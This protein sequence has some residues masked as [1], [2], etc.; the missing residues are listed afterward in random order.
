MKKIYLFSLFLFTC[1]FSNITYSQTKNRITVSSG[2]A[3]N[4]LFKNVR[5][6]GGG[7]S[8]GKG[9]TV[10]GLRYSRMLSNSFSIESGLEYSINR[11]QTTPAF[12]P[13]I[14]QTPKKSSI[15]MLSLPVYGN[16]N[17]LKYLFVNAGAILDF[18]TINSENRST[19]VDK[20]SGVGY[21]IGLGGKYTFKKMTV[22][23]NPFFQSH[24][25]IP[26]EKNKY[27]ERLKEVGV[28]LGIGYNF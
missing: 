22:S 18:E 28:K 14:D 8:E 1:L 24:A 5:I 15:Q 27:P 6:E 3:A 21:G 25:A 17:F 20:Q 23:V 16:Y 26:F 19:S 12:Y 4:G 9:A 7:N 11:I 13:G 10:Y 2:S